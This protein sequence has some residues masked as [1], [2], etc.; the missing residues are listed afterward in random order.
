MEDLNV[1]VGSGWGC[2]RKVPES[3]DYHAPTVLSFG[4][5]NI[6][7]LNYLAV[8][9]HGIVPVAIQRHQYAVEFLDGVQQTRMIHKK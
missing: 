7:S 8:Q 4:K 5:S 1:H 2:R 6:R 9:L 3:L